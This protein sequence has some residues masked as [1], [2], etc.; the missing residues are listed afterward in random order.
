MANSS[1]CAEAIV[2]P[3]SAETDLDLMSRQPCRLVFKKVAQRASIFLEFPIPTHGSDEHAITLAYDANMLSSG[4]QSLERPRDTIHL[5]PEEH[6][7]ITRNKSS[8]MIKHL[9][10]MIKEKCCRILMPRSIENTEREL[11]FIALYDQV[12]TLAK[13]TRIHV[14]F[15]YNYVHKKD[16]SKFMQFILHP[17]KLSGY[18][19][20]VSPEGKLMEVDPFGPYRDTVHDVQPLCVDTVYPPTE[21]TTEAAIPNTPPPYT[22]APHYSPTEKATTVATPGTPPPYTKASNR[23][24]EHTHGLQVSPTEKATTEATSST[25]SPCINASKTHAWQ[26]RFL[27]ARIQVS[28]ITRTRSCTNSS[29]SMSKEPATVWSRH[30]HFEQPRP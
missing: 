22:N 23:Q 28:L 6:A 18:L 14:L 24:S 20:D 19:V 1:F 12:V 30:E 11:G 25:Q 7:A 27:W 13:A 8:G 5:R 4:E 3:D 21:A 10:L 16:R 15:D 17:E 29:V 2:A 26:G 9:T